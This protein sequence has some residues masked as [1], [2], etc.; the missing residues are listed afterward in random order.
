VAQKE[1]WLED[2]GGFSGQCSQPL[3]GIVT[4][5]LF[6]SSACKKRQQAKNE[7]KVLSVSYLYF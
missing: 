4:T 2:S 7:M 1:S 6:W 5:S 3:L